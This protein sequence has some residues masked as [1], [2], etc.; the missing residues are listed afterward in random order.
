MQKLYENFHIFH[1][2]KRIVSAEYIR[3]NAVYKI[4]MIFAYKKTG[5]EKIFKKIFGGLQRLQKLSRF[6]QNK[7]K[8]IRKSQH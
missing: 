6:L 5:L 3:G 2:Q 4:R 1:L 7:I 8:V